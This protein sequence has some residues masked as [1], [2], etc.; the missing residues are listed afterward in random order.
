MAITEPG[1]V[2]LGVVETPSAFEVGAGAKRLGWPTLGFYGVGGLAESVIAFGLGQLLLFYLT[3]VCGLSGSA[4]GFAM[5]IAVVVDAVTQPV[6]GLLSDNSRSEHGRRH[7]F[8]VA[9]A[10]PLAV[11]FGL[12]YSIP[13]GVTGLPLFAYVMAALLV[14][15]LAQ[16]V[17]NVPY[18]ALGAELSEDYQERSVVVATRLWCGSL[19]SAL[20]IFLAYGVFMKGHAGQTHREVYAPFAWSCAAIVLL[21]TSATIIG[22]LRTREG[23]RHGAALHKPFAVRLFGELGKLIKNPSFRALFLMA[24]AFQVAWSA[25]SALGL[26]ANT[27]FWKLPTSKILSINLLGVVGFLAGCVLAAN[28]SK[29]VPKRTTSMLGMGLI[30]LCQLLLVPLRLA[31]VIPDQDVLLAV[32]L[33]T[34]LSQ[35][36]LSMTLVGYQ[37]MMA[38]AA[39]EHEHLFGSRR[40][41]LYYAGTSLAAFASVGIGSIIAG[42]GLDVIKFPHGIAKGSTPVI[43][44]ETLRDLGLLYGPAMGLLT[45][46]AIII[47]FGYRLTKSEH[48]VIRVALSERREQASSGS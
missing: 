28:I 38:D 34:I 13:T 44:A 6:V 16:A 23:L 22:T 4:A 37:S 40:Q 25:A 11:G 39:D 20:A 35:M 5:G 19:G 15:R 31:G 7:P 10:I 18:M 8:M 14:I 36:G 32:T 46:V 42:V 29:F 26:H 24:L 17:F 3:I 12:L 2:L 1:T 9:G 47:L 45:I 33:S 41:G 21:A 27:Y 30:C 43:P 48:A